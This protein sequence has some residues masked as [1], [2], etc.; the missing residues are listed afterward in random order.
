VTLHFLQVFFWFWELMTSTL[1]IKTVEGEPV[2]EA[3]HDE[4]IT[5]LGV[6]ASVDDYWKIG[7]VGCGDA[8][9]GLAHGF[10]G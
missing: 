6:V 7:G 9:F 4:T 1:Q 10:E 2:V 3:H 5:G 8:T